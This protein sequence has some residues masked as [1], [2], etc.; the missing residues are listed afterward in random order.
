[1]GEERRP[2]QG[3]EG[4]QQHGDV[5]GQ[6]EA[7]EHAE[8]AKETVAGEE[9]PVRAHTSPVRV[10]R[11]RSMSSSVPAVVRSMRRGPGP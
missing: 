7:D 11:A 2:G 5:E 1:M 10:E 4:G 3:E 8:N 9:P 6:E